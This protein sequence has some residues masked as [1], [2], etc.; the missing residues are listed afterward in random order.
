MTVD[1]L[2]WSC[3]FSYLLIR[4]PSICAGGPSNRHAPCL[5]SNLFPDPIAYT[6][7]AIGLLNLRFPGSMPVTRYPATYT[8]HFVS[9]HHSAL[10]YYRLGHL[11]N[12]AWFDMYGNTIQ[13]I[14]SAPN[15]S[16]T[17]AP[18][19]T[20]I[21]FARHLAGWE[22][23]FAMVS[24]IMH[25]SPLPSFACFAPFSILVSFLG[26]LRSS[27]EP[28]LCVPVR[29]FV[30]TTFSFVYFQSRF[31]VCPGSTSLLSSAVDVLSICLMLILVWRLVSLLCFSIFCL[32]WFFSHDWSSTWMPS[33]R[34][35]AMA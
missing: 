35:V 16:S 34:E 7:S 27:T 33:T 24:F 31:R 28:W 23:R 12:S 3:R 29:R 13:P 26:F 15:P 14:G 22:R 17:S 8:R 10:R 30:A 5:P 20:C 1:L 19:L 2:S 32:G 9:L 18:F 21:R 4:Q 11:H 6:T 25:N